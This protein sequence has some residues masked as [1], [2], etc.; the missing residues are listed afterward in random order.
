MFANSHF[1]LATHVLVL[2]ALH[3]ASLTSAELAASVNTN[4][5]F[6]R[7]ILGKLRQAG[8]I[9]VVMGKGGGARLARPPARL[10]LADVYNAVERRPA[11]RLHHC[12]PNDKCVVGR[13]IV[14][15]LEGVVHQVESAAVGQLAD[16]TVAQ[17]AD[18]V[19]RR[20]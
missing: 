16:T 9:E 1:A 17:L 12:A 7:S 3:R 8:L 10:T 18:R 11:A 13:N 20:G 5:A 2:L 19:R 14:P 6:L 15:V 4:P